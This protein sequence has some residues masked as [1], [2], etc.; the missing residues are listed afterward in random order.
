MLLCK[1]RCRPRT[2]DT[3]CP[4]KNVPGPVSGLIYQEIAIFSHFLAQQL[5]ITL[6]GLSCG[7][8]VVASQ[9]ESLIIGL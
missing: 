4:F 9:L 8:S 1:K 5:E 3:I 7:P 6:F 2:S